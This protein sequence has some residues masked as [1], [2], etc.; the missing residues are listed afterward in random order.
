[1]R[2]VEAETV[3]TVSD[4]L[5]GKSNYPW[6]FTCKEHG[7]FTS[8]YNKVVNFGTQCPDCAVGG[9]QTLF[10]SIPLHNVCAISGEGLMLQVWDN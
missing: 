8:L 7:D 5:T 10:A 2:R 9:V 4:S 6:V 3:Y 1:M